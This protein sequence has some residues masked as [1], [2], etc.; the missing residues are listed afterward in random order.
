MEKNKFDI[1]D[2]VKVVGY[3]SLMWTNHGDGKVTY[4][5]MRPEMVGQTGIVS[6]AKECQ[7]MWNYALVKIEGKSAWYNED[8]LEMVNRNPNNDDATNAQ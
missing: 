8:Q 5:D 6:I 2:K 3:G 4:K 1:G 7:G